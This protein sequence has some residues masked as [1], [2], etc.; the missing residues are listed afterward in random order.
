MRV[1]NTLVDLLLVDLLVS[2]L[3]EPFRATTRGRG[4]RDLDMAC[5]NARM[6]E[7]LFF[8]HFFL[9]QTLFAMSILRCTLCISAVGCSAKVDLA[10][11]IQQV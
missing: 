4:S 10:T 5:G 1:D 8:I 11:D 7:M 2:Q 3:D 9:C 6:F